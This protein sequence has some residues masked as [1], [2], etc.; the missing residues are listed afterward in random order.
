MSRVAL[1]G[2]RWSLTGSPDEDLALAT[3]HAALDAGVTL[4]DTAYAYTPPGTSGGH[5]ESPI[6][7]GIAGRSVTV[8]T[9]G[10]HWRGP[11]GFLIDGRPSTLRRHFEESLSRLGAIGLYF[12]HWP[13]P[14]VPLRESVGELIRLREEGLVERVGVC[15]VTL[16]RL[17]RLEGIDA[18]QNRF[19]PDIARHCAGHGL[20]YLVHSPFGGPAGAR[21]IAA[22]PVIGEIARDHGVTPHAVALAWLTAQ[23]PVVPIVGAGRPGSVAAFDG[24]RLTLTGTELRR[25]P[26]L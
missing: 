4:V 22:D 21:R 6:A 13:D 10:G 3:L 1:G 20:E 19:S 5:N 16:D 18:V 2:A 8:S 14:A 15:N 12:L 17:R 11:G 9:K 7:R 24:A 23:G 26:G 25:I